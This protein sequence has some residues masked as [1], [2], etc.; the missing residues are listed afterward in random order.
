MVGGLNGNDLALEGRWSKAQGEAL[1]TLGNDMI[2]LLNRHLIQPL[3]AWRTGSKHLTYL[4][5]LKQRQFDSPETIEQRQWLELRQLLQ[6]AFQTVPYYRRQFEKLQLAPESFRSLADLSQLPILTKADIRTHAHDLHSSMKFDRPLMRKT[7]SGSTG[8]PLEI[9]VDRDALEWKMA[10]TIRSDEW[11]NWRLGRRVAKV[12][13]NPEYLKQGI[14]GR[15]RNYFI[16]RAQHLDTLGFD[17]QRLA[18]FANQL[19]KKQPSLLFGH[20][21]SLYLLACHVRQNAANT[22]HPDG[23]ISTAMILHDWQREVI[24]EAFGCKVTNRYGCEEVSLIASECECHRGLH[25]NADSLYAE[26]VPDSERGDDANTGAL[27]LTDLRNRAMPLIRYKVG[28]VVV[29]ST[30]RCA[31]GRGLPLIE[32]VEGREADYIVTPSGQL[33]S[34]ISLTENFAMEIP[35]AEQVQ[36]V[37][38]ELRFLRIRMVAGNTFGQNA[39]QRLAELVRNT[40]GSEMGY[41]IELVDVIPQEPS[42]KYR[43][44]ISKV[45]SEYLKALAK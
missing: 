9:Y 1:R 2:S 36:L 40:F 35:G 37:Q 3:M 13:G 24:E 23:I 20:A 4:R 45:S 31:C 5:E 14:K 8:V 29:K 12:W 15:I 38:E 44:C 17:P 39:R 28:D 30:R 43:F 10:C 22:I 41:E 19:R 21:H 18:A 16:D 6:R 25:L 34:G 27:V 7:T 11:T 32:Q 26:V 33:I 42:G